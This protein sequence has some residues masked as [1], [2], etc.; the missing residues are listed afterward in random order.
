M[1]KWKK[2]A[3]CPCR[4]RALS[5]SAV[6]G[7]PQRAFATGLILR[8][9]ATVLPIFWTLRIVGPMSDEGRSGGRSR[10]RLVF[11]PLLTPR[12]NSKG[13]PRT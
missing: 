13:D 3:I 4:E 5:L 10:V 9:D 12:A 11:F 6:G 2:W 8:P 7:T 1:G